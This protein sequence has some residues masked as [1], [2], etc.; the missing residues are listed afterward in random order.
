MKEPHTHFTKLCVCV[1][2]C[3]RA[4]VSVYVRVCVSASACVCEV[5][6]I[7]IFL[8]TQCVSKSVSVRSTCLVLFVMYQ[9]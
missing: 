8:H 2:V 9:S 4:C 7:K 6:V 1:L 3:V 5:H